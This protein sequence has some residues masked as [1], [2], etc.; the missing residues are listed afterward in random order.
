LTLASWRFF[1]VYQGFGGTEGHKEEFANTIAQFTNK[2]AN[3]KRPE[4]FG[5]GNQTRDFTHVDDVVRACELAVNHELQEIYAVGTAESYTFNEM[6]E[7]INDELATNVDPKYIENP[8]TVYVHDI[9]PTTRSSKR[10]RA[11][12]PQ[13]TSRRESPASV[14]RTSTPRS[15]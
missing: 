4:M 2:I 13:S 14:N 7:I 5:N 8:L 11:G 15:H 9:W 12:N 3:G 10:L 1:S 6:V